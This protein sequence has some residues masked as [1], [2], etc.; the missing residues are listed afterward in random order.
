M[1][2]Q[3]ILVVDDE[4]D[5]LH[6]LNLGL[7]AHGYD[8]VVATDGLSAVTVAREQKPDLILL[9]IVMPAG[10]G[11]TVMDRLANMVPLAMV[12]VIVITG[13][14]GLENMERAEQAGVKGYLKK[15]FEMDELLEMIQKTLQ[16]SN[17][18]TAE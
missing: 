3:K 7:R 4:K 18:Q 9:D 16:T 11:F 1:N 14:E 15:P 10:D 5:L 8:V 12:P 17:A 6:I 13:T 2:N